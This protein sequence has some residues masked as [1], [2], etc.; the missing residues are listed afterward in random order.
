MH[1]LISFGGAAEW[2]PEET[3]HERERCQTVDVCSIHVNSKVGINHF[4]ASIETR[5]PKNKHTVDGDKYR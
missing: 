4:R 2:N 5:R 3:L 1:E